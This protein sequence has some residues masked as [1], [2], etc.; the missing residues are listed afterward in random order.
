VNLFVGVVDAELLEAVDVERFEAVDV[1]HADEDV[2]RR[3]GLLVPLQILVQRN[4]E[5]VKEA[6]VEHHCKR[7]PL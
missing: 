6:R 7:I 4:D 1:E 2:I 5:P 3:A